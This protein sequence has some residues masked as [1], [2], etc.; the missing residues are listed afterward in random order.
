[1]ITIHCKELYQDQVLRKAG[2]EKHHKGDGYVRDVDAFTRWHA[3]T[4]KKTI[5]VHI[6]KT[7]RKNNYHY[8]ARDKGA[9]AYEASRLRSIKAELYYTPPQNNLGKIKFRKKTDEVAPNVLELQRNHKAKKV[10][11]KKTFKESFIDWLKKLLPIA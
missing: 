3:H 2:Y 4:F 6:D 9:E 8:V 10:V 1:M 7:N 5:E 11:L